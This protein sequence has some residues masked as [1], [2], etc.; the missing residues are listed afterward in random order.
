MDKFMQEYFPSLE[1][2][3]EIEKKRKN[4]EEIAAGKKKKQRVT[5]RTLDQVEEK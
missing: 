2:E 1:Y 5:G 4:P 3:E